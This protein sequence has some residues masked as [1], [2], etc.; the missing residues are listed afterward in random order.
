LLLAG[1]SSVKREKDFLIGDG[2]WWDD[3]EEVSDSEC[4][5]LQN[6]QIFDPLSFPFFPTSVRKNR[7]IYFTTRTKFS[8]SQFESSLR[9]ND[10]PVSCI[11]SIF[12]LFF[13]R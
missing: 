11:K 13:A 4:E 7:K 10:S 9:D 12:S 8:Y 6:D 5:R 3:E 2:C 1:W